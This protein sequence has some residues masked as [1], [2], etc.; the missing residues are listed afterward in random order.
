MPPTLTA[1]PTQDICTLIYI[2]G[3]SRTSNVAGWWITNNSGATITI[4]IID[5]DW[6]PSNDA[7]FNIFVNG[8]VVW[9]DEDTQPPTHIASWIGSPSAREVHSTASLEAF[10]GTT[11]AGSGYNLDVTFDNGCQASAGN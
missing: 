6:P 3:F 11:A 7:L 10:F 4:E 9:S 5:L 8:S 1:T 2:G